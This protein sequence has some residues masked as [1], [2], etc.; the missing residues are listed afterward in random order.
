[1]SGFRFRAHTVCITTAVLIGTVAGDSDTSK[2]LD[3]TS[4]LQTSNSDSVAQAKKR[5]R[6]RSVTDYSQESS[7]FTQ[8]DF[9]HLD[10]NTTLPAIF[11]WRLQHGAVQ[12]VQDQGL[13]AASEA[14]A[15][16]AA[17]ETA[18][19]IRNGRSN[20]LSVQQLISCVDEYHV[21]KV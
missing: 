4:R 16:I 17:L 21:G 2:F 3:R 1:M 6:F 8:N 13:C 10:S 9:S 12:P 15:A 19:F 20:A 14:F 7:D 5:F 18:D 11:D